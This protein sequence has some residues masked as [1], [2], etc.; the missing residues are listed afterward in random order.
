MSKYCNNTKYSASIN[1]NSQKSLVLEF[2][3]VAGLFGL[4]LIPLFYNIYNFAYK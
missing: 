2:A 4:I 3:I 1:L